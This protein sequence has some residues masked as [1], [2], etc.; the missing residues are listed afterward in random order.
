MPSKNKFEFNLHVYNINCHSLASGS[1]S[2]LPILE[3]H[4]TCLIY[5]LGDGVVSL[6]EFLAV[7]PAVTGF[8]IKASQY[9]FY[10]IDLLEPYGTVST[11]ETGYAFSKIAMG[12]IYIQHSFLQSNSC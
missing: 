5:F 3:T 6:T 11:Q 8:T 2:F 10:S 12:M 4:Q 1:W 9:V 7:Y